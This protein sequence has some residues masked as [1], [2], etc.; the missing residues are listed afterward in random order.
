VRGEPTD[1]RGLLR[2]LHKLG[3]D[4]ADPF[5]SA[6]IG[7]VY[8]MLGMDCNLRCR[9]CTLWGKGGACR[10]AA[11]LKRVSRPA[12]LGRFLNF[13]DELRPFRP[14]YLNI[15]GGEPL[16]TR[17]WAPLA[18]AAR[19][20]GISTILTT[21]GVYLEK[22]ARRVAALFDQVNIS[23]ACPPSLRE[24]LGMGPPGHYAAL[25]R[26]LKALRRLADASKDGKPVLRLMCEVF[27]ANGSH[28]L[29]LVDHLEEEGVRFDEILFMH[30][31][32]N[33][34]ETLSLQREALASEFGAA[35]GLWKGYGYR[36]SGMDYARL[37]RVV[38]TLRERLPHARFN[39]D[40]A[41][42]R[43]LRD[44]YE[45][46]KAGL[47]RPFC[48]G[49]W[50]QA[51]LFPNGDVWACPDVIL[52]NI[53]ERPFAEIWDGPRARSLRRRVYQKLFP[54]CRGCFSFYEKEQPI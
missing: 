7:E 35:F 10:H 34:P 6:V 1:R 47:S 25:L 37:H 22:H 27:D 49:P 43:A 33:R 19:K 36:P 15:S 28:L 8:I 38:E 26:G 5:H 50:R 16:M 17:R 3:L 14:E 21:N 53:T 13:I 41:G 54:T 18:E 24:K 48:E 2:Q 46:R 44:Y 42:P 40:L 29:E 52:G 45:G 31:I 12:P 9:A 23:I 11:F 4:P 20:A 39:V 51:N 32:F 30:L